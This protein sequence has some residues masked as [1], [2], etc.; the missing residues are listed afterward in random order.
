MSEKLTL[1]L[2]EM[3]LLPGTQAVL[4]LSDKNAQDM[5]LSCYK[6]SIPFGVLYCKDAQTVAETAAH[7]GC[8]ANVVDC[9]SY[10]DGTFIARVDGGERFKAGPLEVRKDGLFESTYAPLPEDE[11]MSLDDKVFDSILHLLD[12]YLDHLEAIDSDLVEDIPDDLSGFDLTFL[13]L[14]YMSISEDIRQEG[15]EIT[16][17]KKRAHFCLNLLRQEIA[18]LKFLISGVKDEDDESLDEITQPER[19]N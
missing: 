1:L 12:I 19:M 10:E 17:L 3:V 11:D 8:L 2:L 4:R 13:V 5:V 6:E 18:R 7:V 9:K 14:D 16:S 15:L